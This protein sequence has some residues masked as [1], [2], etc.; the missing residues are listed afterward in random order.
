WMLGSPNAKD[1]YD[2]S[3]KPLADLELPPLPAPSGE[4]AFFQLPDSDVKLLWD[5][6][7]LDDTVDVLVWTLLVDIPEEKTAELTWDNSK[8]P[9]GWR[10]TIAGDNA[11]IHVDMEVESSLVIEQSGLSTFV[12]TAI[13]AD[14]YATAAY[15]LNIGW[16]IISL[17]LEMTQPSKAYLRGKKLWSVD[18]E[19]GSYQQVTSVIPG[20]AY[21]FFSHAN[22]E[23][24]LDGLKI[25]DPGFNLKR[26]WNFVAPAVDMEISVDD[27]VAWRWEQKNYLPP[28][29][30]D[31]KYQL[32][33]KKGYWIFNLIK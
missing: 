29:V 28:E 17:P 9:E 25:Q 4:E 14:L 12:V 19:R 31:G 10:L 24:T 13:R 11:K 26:D 21:W 7:F 32:L 1:D 15:D 6:H 2:A 18:T 20:K 3:D 23:I 22:Q 33:A 5:A 8:I 27:I 16:N 30:I